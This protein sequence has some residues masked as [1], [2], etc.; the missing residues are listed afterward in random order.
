MGDERERRRLFVS[1]TVLDLNE[2]LGRT[3][4]EREG[5]SSPH[6]STLGILSN[7]TL[8]TFTKQEVLDDFLDVAFIVVSFA[9]STPHSLFIHP[10]L[11]ISVLFSSSLPGTKQRA[12]EP[13]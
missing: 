10:L 7:A 11:I 2:H 9:K 4:V 1:N 6:G 13:N 8:F 3:M 12:P 5:R